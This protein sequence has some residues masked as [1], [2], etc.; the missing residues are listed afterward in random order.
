MP[1]YSFACDSCNHEW[2][3]SLGFV[4]RDAPKDERCPECERF[5]QIRRTYRLNFSNDSFAKPKVDSG[6]K[7]VLR[8]IKKANKGSTIEV[9]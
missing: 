4:A 5:G 6:M 2:E 1:M 7:D 8:E 9:D 3:Q